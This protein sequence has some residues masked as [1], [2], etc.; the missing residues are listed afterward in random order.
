MSY[1]NVSSEDATK[2]VKTA[3]S[4]KVIASIVYIDKDEYNV[5][6]IEKLEA[7]HLINEASS[8]Y[9]NE[10]EYVPYIDL[11]F[12]NDNKLVKLLFGN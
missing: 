1:Y 6:E 8:I 7:F 2:I 4:N 9:Y 11:S 3:K 12:K 5:G 10:D